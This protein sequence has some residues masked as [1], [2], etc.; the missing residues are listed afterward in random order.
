MVMDFAGAIIHVVRDGVEV[1]M[2]LKTRE[3][4]NGRW[5]M[6]KSTVVKLVI[7]KEGF[8]LWNTYI[9]EE[10]V[11]F[12]INNEN[13]LEVRYEIYLQSHLERLKDN[14]LLVDK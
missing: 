14:E 7:R 11:F 3:T 12:R 5:K 1:V 13:F 9:D 8:A 2:R 6:Q 10:E 4:K